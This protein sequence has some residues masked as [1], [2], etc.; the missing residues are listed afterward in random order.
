MSK[1]GFGKS[2][3]GIFEYYLFGLQPYCEIIHR[4]CHFSFI[5]CKKTNINSNFGYSSC[6]YYMIE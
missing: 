3:A 2:Y 5:N 1:D 6:E 4:L